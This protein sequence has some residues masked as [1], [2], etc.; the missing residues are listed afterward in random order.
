MELQNSS[1]N[2]KL[3]SSVLMISYTVIFFRL[4]NVSMY[5]DTKARDFYHGDSYSDINAHST[6]MY[7]FDYGFLQSKLLPVWHY[8]GDNDK[9]TV[10]VYTHYPALPDVLAGVYAK[11]F[12][13]KHEIYIRIIPIAFS[14]VFVF[15]IFFVLNLFI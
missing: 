5:D 13:S 9:S 12:N 3:I 11:L 15:V 14:F 8:K 1:W 7:M 10:S 6:G 2:W 4:V